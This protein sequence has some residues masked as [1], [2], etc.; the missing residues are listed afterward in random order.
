MAKQCS[1]TNETGIYAGSETDG[2]TMTKSEYKAYKKNVDPKTLTDLQLKAILTPKQQLFC[3][4]YL[5]YNDIKKAAIEAGYAER[6]AYLS[7]H[8]LVA[9]NKFSM[10]Y[11]KRQHDQM[12]TASI[13]DAREILQYLTDVMRG[14]I[15]D[16][17]GLDAPL[18]ERTKA[19]QELAKR[20]I[21]LP[22][23]MG[24]EDS[25]PKIEITLMR[26]SPAPKTV[27]ETIVDGEATESDVNE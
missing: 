4:N 2:K 13:A 14:E 5:K 7:G 17:F 23:K 21:D 8:A 3:S 15:K 16:Q 20:Q 1:Y 22:A 9:K 27:E 11:I 26:S 12:Q 18:A 19:A 10:E 24:S 6:S 25:A